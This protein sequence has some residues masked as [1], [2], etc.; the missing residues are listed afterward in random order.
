MHHA[1]RLFVVRML[2]RDR[3]VLE[4]QPNRLHGVGVGVGR[5]VNRNASLER[6]RQAVDAGIGGQAFRHRHDELRIDDRHVGSQRVIGQRHLAPALL[7]DQDGKGSD[8]AAGAAGRGD[9]NQPRPIDFF[10]RILDHALAHIEKRRCQIFQ[11]GFRRFV[12][13]LHD[14]RRV[15]HRPAAQ[16]DDLVRLVE[17]ERLHA[18]VMTLTSG[19]ASGMTST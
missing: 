16:R 1:A 4:H 14:L 7:V 6:V 3:Q 11:V 8:F 19:S 10:G 12:L 2:V 5:S 18:R 15:D 9:G 13:Q 17:I